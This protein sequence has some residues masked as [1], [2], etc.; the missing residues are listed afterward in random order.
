MNLP[1]TSKATR[2]RQNSKSCPGFNVI[3]CW[4]FGSLSTPVRL[5]NTIRQLKPDVVWFN[6]VFSSFA[7]PEN[8]FAAFCRSVCACAHAGLGFL[9][10]YHAAPHDRARRFCRCRGAGR[11][12][13]LRMGTDFATRTLLKAHSVSVLLPPTGA[14]WLTK[15]AVRNVLLAAR[16]F[17]IH[18]DTSG[19]QQA[20]QSG[21]PYSGH[22]ALGHLQAAG[23]A[24]GGVSTVLKRFRMPAD[25]RRRQSSHQ[26]GVL[27]IDPR[28]AACQICP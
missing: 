10:P 27:G 15:Y 25:C 28:G 22:W 17:R 23:D 21:T 1:P 3:R 12:K 19:F 11:E 7:T 8:P 6:L 18:S 2:S 24:D 14:R 5:L 13:L 4:K 16:D 20:R 9:H 26:G